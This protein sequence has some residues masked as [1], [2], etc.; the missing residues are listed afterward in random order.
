MIVLGSMSLAMRYLIIEAE[1]VSMELEVEQKVWQKKQNIYL[2][3]HT[4]SL[5]GLS[6]RMNAS[7]ISAVLIVVAISYEIYWLSML[8][9]L[10]QKVKRAP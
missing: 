7:A 10:K 3:L 1:K 8:A 5:I 9:Q 6:F 4:L 2:V